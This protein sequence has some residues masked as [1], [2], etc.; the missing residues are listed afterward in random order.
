MRDFYIG[1]IIFAFI[2]WAIGLFI[3]SVIGFQKSFKSPPQINKIEVQRL[4]AEQ[5]QRTDD[6][7]RRYQLLRENYRQK[8]R[9]SRKKF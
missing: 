5:E 1:I 7:K 4:K 2:L 8:M 9:D 3:A 6:I